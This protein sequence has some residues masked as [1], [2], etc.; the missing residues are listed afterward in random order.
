ML[1]MWI[2]MMLV[3]GMFIFDVDVMVLCLFV[4]IFFEYNNISVLIF[5][6]KSL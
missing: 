1:S 6:N 4:V 5:V 3:I 2:I